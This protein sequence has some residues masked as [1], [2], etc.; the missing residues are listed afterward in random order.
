[1]TNLTKDFSHR[2]HLIEKIYTISKSFKNETFPG[3][4]FNFETVSQVMHE[5]RKDKQDSFAFVYSIVSL[6]NNSI[7]TKRENFFQKNRIFY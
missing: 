2:H 4:N 3:K 6:E 7:K 1:M 5:S